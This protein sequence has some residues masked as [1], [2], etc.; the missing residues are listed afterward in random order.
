MRI[1]QS[2]IGRFD[3]TRG[4]TELDVETVE[5]W[6]V[7]ATQQVILDQAP[8]TPVITAAAYSRKLR[9]LVFGKGKSILPPGWVAARAVDRADSASSSVPVGK[10]ARTLTIGMPRHPNGLEHESKRA[11]RSLGLQNPTPGI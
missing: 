8:V 6:V 4:G 3:L 7:G 9:V 1:L 2:H 11:T 10:R 5:T